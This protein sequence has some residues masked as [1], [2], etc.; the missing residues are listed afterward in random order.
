[1]NA[2]R[3]LL[4]DDEPHI[5]AALSRQLRQLLRGDAVELRIEQ[6]ADPREALRLLR[7]RPYALL[8]SD[9]RMP[10]LSGVEL[11]REARRL[12]PHCTRIL[13]SGQVDRDGLAGAINEAAVHRFM[14]KPW[15]DDELA[16]EVR[17]GLAEH[18][19][20][21]REAETLDQV[22]AEAGRLSPQDRELRRLERLEPGITRVVRDNDGAVLMDLDA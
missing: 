9:Y 5:L 18:E 12:Q 7:E 11:L 19:R 20:L 10:G 4:V 14:S 15:R 6:A 3:L 21:R 2:L 13:L 1:M 16:R 22:A 17:A 8:I